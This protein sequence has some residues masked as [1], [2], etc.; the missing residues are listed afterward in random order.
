MVDNAKKLKSDVEIKADGKYLDATAVMAAAL[1][2]D[3]KDK[4]EEYIKGRFDSALELLDAD[5][6]AKQ[7]T[8]INDDGKPSESAVDKHRAKFYGGKA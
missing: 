2:I 8:V 6:I 7:R 3:A 1:N 5:A 4:S